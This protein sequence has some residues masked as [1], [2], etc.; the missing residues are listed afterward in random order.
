MRVRAGADSP[1][2]VTM[3]AMAA[4]ELAVS[5]AAWDP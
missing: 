4:F 2:A 5:T 1:M 3:P